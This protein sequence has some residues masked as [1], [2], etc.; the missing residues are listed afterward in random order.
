MKYNIFDIFPIA[1][2]GNIIG[3]VKKDNCNKAGIS[4]L[5]SLRKTPTKEKITTYEAIEIRKPNKEKIT[6][7]GYPRPIFIS[8]IKKFLI[9]KTKTIGTIPIAKFINW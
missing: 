5:K 4:C 3:D 6:L 1:E 7:N 2:D 9:N 8:I